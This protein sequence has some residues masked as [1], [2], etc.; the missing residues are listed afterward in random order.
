[1]SAWT[2]LDQLLD[3]A[4]GA[5]SACVQLLDGTPVYD[6][7]ADIVRPSASLIKVPLA[8]ALVA[9]SRRQGHEGVDL[10]VTE[11]LCE[12]DRVE[13]DGTFDGAPAGTSRTRW[14]L[15]GHMLRESDNTAG[16]L[17]IRA[18]GMDTVNRFL[19][20]PLLCLS[21]TRLRRHF[22][23]FAA[24][25]AGEENLITAREM[26]RILTLLAAEPEYACLREWLTQSPYDER[27]VAGVPTG[28]AVAHKV[29]DLTGVE[30]DAGIVYAPHVPYIVTML[31]VDLPAPGDG[32]R[33]IAG[34]SRLIY[35]LMT[36]SALS[37]R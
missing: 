32:N 13:G 19:A 9:S 31:S 25:A 11:T 24:A 7:A 35:T 6:Y 29:G 17:L 8:M 26:C 5:W 23:D 20:G 33:T 16:N 4:P 18:I 27:L 14:E 37:S 28:I 1:M 34:A 12:V 15:I 10:Q 36:G 3:A 2:E 21:T 30:H 22:M